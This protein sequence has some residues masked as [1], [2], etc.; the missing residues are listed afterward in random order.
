MVKV[1]E[2]EHHLADGTIDV[3]AWLRGLY[4]KYPNLDISVVRHACFLEQIPEHATALDTL[5]EGLAI[6]E[7]LSDLDVD[8]ETLAAA[9]IYA[10][11]QHATIELEDVEEQLGKPIAKLVS[12]ACR[13]NAVHYMSGFKDAYAAQ[14]QIDNIRRMLLAMVDDVRGVLIKL[15]ERLHAL[16]GASHV[17]HSVQR[18]I[19]KEIVDIYAPLANRL[20]LGS[21]KWEMEDLAFRYLEPEKYKEIAQGLKAKRLERDVYVKNVVH[22]LKEALQKCIY[23]HYEVY[24]RSK[25]IHSIYRKMQRKNVS[26]SEVYDATA[27]RVL[28][29]T[30]EECYTVLSTVHTLWTQ[31][32]SEFD[33]YIA[34]P[35][36]NGY[37]SLHTAVRGPENRIFEVQIRTQEMDALAELGVA[38]HWKYKEGAVAVK[39]SHERK[40]EWLR[41]VLAWHKELA[42]VEHVPSHIEMEF[43]EDRVYVF[44]PEGEVLDLPQGG[45]ALDFAYHIHSD[46]GHR[47]RGAKINGHMV[48]LTYPLKTGDQVEILTGKHPKPSRDWLN[49]HLGYLKSTRAKTKIIHWFKKQDFERNSA[50]GMEILEREFRKLNIRHVS[51]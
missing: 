16:R 37:R 35:K 42:E 18:E 39:E 47:C 50:D 2:D 13:M 43:L 46:V 23:S 22:H 12:T 17:S 24:G 36:S 20:G 48:Q 19:S 51:I 4:Q 40:I 9:I 11:V 6:A 29:Q 10:S 5:Q 33:D 34:H 7:I 14:G 32:P 38:A 41:D 26:L 45:T 44:T 8:L 31:I 15:A 21:I 3:E 49:P 30:E 27:V 1:K 25:H 28:V